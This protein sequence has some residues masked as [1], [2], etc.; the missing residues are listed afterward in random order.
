MDYNRK[1]QKTLDKTKQAMGNQKCCSC[2]NYYSEYP[3]KMA[4]IGS[5]LRRQTCSPYFELYFQK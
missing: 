2:V 1:Y 3:K 4:G 5:I